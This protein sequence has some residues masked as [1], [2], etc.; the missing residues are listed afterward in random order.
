[1]SRKERTK[2]A[3]PRRRTRHDGGLPVT[4]RRLN[5]HPA[6]GRTYHS[7]TPRTDP[8]VHMDSGEILEL[9]ET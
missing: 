5:H 4:A 1:M 8:G 6:T 2:D 7:H 3:L 9:E